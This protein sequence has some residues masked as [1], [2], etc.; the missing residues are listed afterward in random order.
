MPYFIQAVKAFIQKETSSAGIHF[1]KQYI[2]CKF[3]TV[4]AFL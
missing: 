2:I 4:R 1:F 3:I